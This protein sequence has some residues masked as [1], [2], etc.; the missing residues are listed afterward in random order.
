MNKV[1]NINF[2]LAME[3]DE[4][5]WQ[6]DEPHNDILETMQDYLE[7]HLPEKWRV[8]LIDSTYA[9]VETDK[10]IRLAIHASGDGDSTHHKVVFEAI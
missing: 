10:G 5:T 3:A 1:N 6:T 9:E 4:Y 8:W 7:F 2:E